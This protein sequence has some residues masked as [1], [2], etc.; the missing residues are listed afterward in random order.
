[1]NGFR[2][3]LITLS[4][5]LARPLGLAL[6]LALASCA[7][8]REPE[9]LSTAKANVKAYAESGDYQKDL[10]AATT[11]ATKWVSTRLAKPGEKTA[12][13]FDIDETTLSNLPHMTK[14][15]WGYQ[16]DD[17]EAWI[18]K[19]AAPAIVPSRDIYQAAR[20]R[21]TAVFFIT[22]RGQ[23]DKAATARNL[24]QQGMGDFKELIVRP[25]GPKNSA[26]DFKTAVRKNITA[27]GY[28][29]IANVGDQQSD[30]DGGY[31]EKTF[32]LPNPFYFIN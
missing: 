25:A 30:L 21:G 28:T 18:Q 7:T 5:P 9:N 17:W 16:P 4:L 13:V 26:K 2:S 29:I 6:T 12:I 31:S 15:D 22:G 27:Q 24:R 8:T 1:M 32:K 11:P 14:A 23:V 20:A 19:S 10:A 3:R